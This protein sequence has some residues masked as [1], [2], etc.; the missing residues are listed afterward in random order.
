MRRRN[1]KKI[2]DLFNTELAQTQAQQDFVFI[3]LRNI[4]SVFHFTGVFKK[5]A[6]ITLY[7][8]LSF[9]LFTKRSY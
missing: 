4:R 9:S 3:S 7:R 2:T 1:N 6:F 8:F 5:T